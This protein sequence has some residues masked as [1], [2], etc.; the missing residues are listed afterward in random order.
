M[1]IYHNQYTYNF[2]ELCSAIKL[3]CMTYTERNEPE[4]KRVTQTGFFYKQNAILKVIEKL[5]LQPTIIRISIRRR[6]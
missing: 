6:N 1:C 5:K 2:A 3:Y 4:N